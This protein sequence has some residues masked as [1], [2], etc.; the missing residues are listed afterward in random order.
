MIDH[1]APRPF[2]AVYGMLFCPR[3][4]VSHNGIFIL[5]RAIEVFLESPGL[6]LGVQIIGQEWIE[7]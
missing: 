6:M 7:H 1:A 4:I 2:A 3:L 5:P